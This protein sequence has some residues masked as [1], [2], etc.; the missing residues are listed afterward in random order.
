[1]V[2]SLARKASYLS[3][4]VSL[5]VL[6]GIAQD[7][8]PPEIRD[9][10]SAFVKA[11][12]S[13]SPADWESMAQQHYTPSQL[14]RRTSDERKQSFERLRQL[15]GNI[16][17]TG[18]ERESPDAPL[19][20]QVKGA[21]GSSGVIEMELEPAAPY[22]INALRVRVGGPAEQGKPGIVAPPVNGSM[23]AEQMAQALDPYFGALASED[24][25]SGNVL[26]AKDGKPI[27]ERSFGFADRG[28]KIPNTSATRFNL[29]SINKTF[30]QTAI[31][32]LISAGKL[33]L[34]DT[35]G[36][37]LP[38]YPQ[39][40]TR[41]ATVDQ[42]LHHTAGVANFFGDEFSAAA[43]DR[44]RSN[45]DYYKFVSNMKPLFAPGTGNQ[46][47][48]GCYIVLG[49]IV[50]QLS[51]VP[52]EKY[53]EAHVFIPAGMRATGALQADAL[54]PNVAMG[55]TRL[56]GPFRSN[57]YTRGAAGSAAGGGYSSATDLLAYAQ[58]LKSG[59]MPGVPAASDFGF[60]GGAP[61]IS[62]SLEQNGPWTVIVLTNLDPQLGEELGRVVVQA[63]AR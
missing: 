15:F 7:G 51:G 54:E 45:A 40:T 3:F 43:K 59:R 37:L 52:Y 30:T 41:T 6:A 42:L 10:I 38:Q 33:S 21:T 58:A 63:L 22:R 24:K 29:G 36:K 4:A 9:H 8:P 32:Q 47:C 55:Y 57:V 13:P 31:Q 61:G 17:I 50:E 28:A 46:Y 48:N 20:L 49:Q 11:V 35:V 18:I 1:M 5:F 56:D 25:F 44:F 27:Y 53:V 60:A 12:N 23:S 14:Q 62:S 16:S 34:T 39:E 26:I 19:E 2:F